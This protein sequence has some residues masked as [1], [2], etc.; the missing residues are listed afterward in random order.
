LSTVCCAAQVL[1]LLD[2]FEFIIIY[3]SLLYRWMTKHSDTQRCNMQVKAFVFTFSRPNPQL[4]AAMAAAASD[5]LPLVQDDS[6][7]DVAAHIGIH[8]FEPRCSVNDW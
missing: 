6:D 3:Y 8:C 1:Y 7:D 2:T 4:C 5:V